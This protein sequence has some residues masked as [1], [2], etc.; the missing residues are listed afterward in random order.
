MPAPSRAGIGRLP[1]EYLCCARA[2]RM[3]HYL[4]T[5]RYRN[6]IDVFLRT[7]G[8][9]LAGRIRRLSYERAFAM[10]SVPAGTWIFSDLE[11][12]SPADTERAAALWRA[13]ATSGAPVRLVNHP[14]RALRR[15]ELLRRLHESGVNDFDVRRLTEARAPRRFPVFLRREH[16]H[17]GAA[18]DLLHTP[19]ELAAAVE[20]LEGRGESRED[21]LVVELCDTADASGVYR[22]Y[23]AFLLAGRIVPRHVFGSRRWMIK[24]PELFDD[25]SLGVEDEY[26]ATNPHAAA[27]ARI[28]AL[29]RVD[30][31]RI[32]YGL[33]EGRIQVWEINTNPLLPTFHGPG[34]SAR[35]ALNARVA[36][37]LIEAFRALDSVDPD[38]AA[39]VAT[40]FAG[41][42]PLHALSRLTRRTVRE[43][44]EAAVH[45]L[46]AFR[47]RR[48]DEAD[49]ER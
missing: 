18:T 37:A 39:R 35:A 40:G 11:R 45:R 3:I 32:D 42:R 5:D 41:G 24:V 49:R 12:L 17:E 7:H 47:R 25:E 10:R 28:F 15:Y 21:V 33:L 13:L 27:L 1:Q 30:Y 2:A 23:A 26:V 36:C 44:A 34:G 16:D 19:A 38:P 29:A 31:G 6:T 14:G 48:T 20:A 22:K 9:S 43:Y 4:V 46:R 8:R